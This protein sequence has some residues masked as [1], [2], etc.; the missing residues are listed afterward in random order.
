MLKG[1][2]QGA[3]WETV[4]NRES[5]GLNGLSAYDGAS[6]IVLCTAPK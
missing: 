4:A 3:V 2:K 5:F 1:A 6:E